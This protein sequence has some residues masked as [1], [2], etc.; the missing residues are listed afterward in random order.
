MTTK[1]YFNVPNPRAFDN[2]SQDEGRMIK[3]L[4]VMESTGDPQRCLNNSAGN[5]RM[6]GC[7]IFY[8]K[9]QE[10]DTVAT[11]ILVGVPNTMEEKITKQIME[12][13]LKVLEYKLL[14]T[15][16]NSKLTRE[17]SRTWVKYMVVRE[18]PARMPWEG[19]EE[20]KQKQGTSNARLA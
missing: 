5:L 7:A 13:E 11:Q 6:I 14:L 18:F 16:K 1:N 17:Q 3:G 12:E 9:C 2:V 15:D 10:A 20:K 4:A 8:K 19:T